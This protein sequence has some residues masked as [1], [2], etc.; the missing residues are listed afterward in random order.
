MALTSIKPGDANWQLHMVNSL[1]WRCP[2][3]LFVE[4]EVLTILPLEIKVALW[5]KSCYWVLSAG[6]SLSNGRAGKVVLPV[7]KPRVCLPCCSHQLAVSSRLIKEQ[8]TGGFVGGFWRLGF[9]TYWYDYTES[10]PVDKLSPRSLLWVT[11][12]MNNT[13]SETSCKNFV[14]GFLV[15]LGL[16]V[17]C[18]LGLGFVFSSEY[19]CFLASWILKD[20]IYLLACGYALWL[21]FIT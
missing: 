16:D 14:G 18:G 6:R 15:G 11:G 7:T 13:G 2:P 1:R 19:L 12:R 17:F 21:F 10:S 3:G 9:D 8:L 20:P 5:H 4:E